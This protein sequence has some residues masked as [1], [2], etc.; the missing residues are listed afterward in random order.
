M[1]IIPCI[2]TTCSKLPIFASSRIDIVAMMVQD[3][4]DLVLAS[5]SS[6]WILHGR[7]TRWKLLGTF[8]IWIFAAL[9][10]NNTNLCHSV[11]HA[12]LLVSPPPITPDL[13]DM[14]AYTHAHD[15]HDKHDISRGKVCVYCFAFSLIAAWAK[16]DSVS[17]RLANV[18]QTI[19]QWA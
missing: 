14:R 9:V 16:R 8:C 15:Y 11:L 5:C 12:L 2:L 6:V 17:C 7:D 4:L 19:C 3:S 13:I 10:S 1:I 18:E